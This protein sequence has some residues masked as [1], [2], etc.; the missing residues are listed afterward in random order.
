MRPDEHKKK[1]RAEYKKKHGISN[2]KTA[3]RERHETTKDVNPTE[4]REEEALADTDEGDH[5]QFSR[6]N[7]SSNWDRY[8]DFEGSSDEE[9]STTNITKRG[10][11]FN[12]LLQKSE[13]PASQFRFQ[14]EKDLDQEIEGDPSTTQVAASA[15]EINFGALA[16]SLNCV[17]LHK[18]LDISADG[19]HSDVV[20]EFELNAG[21]HLKDQC[22]LPWSSDDETPTKHTVKSTTTITTESRPSPGSALQH[23]LSPHSTKTNEQ[24][25]IDR[26]PEKSGNDSKQ[27]IQSMKCDGADLSHVKQAGG[28]S[29]PRSLHNKENLQNS[30]KDVL[31]TVNT[32]SKA[33]HTGEQL[34]QLG[35][36]E[37]DDELEF[38]LSLETPGGKDSAKS[39]NGL[40]SNKV[41]KR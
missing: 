31:K 6:R 9:D 26:T 35:N 10:E 13:N 34:V 20:K 17:P 32:S 5:K 7:V 19:I 3:S 2:K 36:N 16:A 37:D 21:L 4:T 24:D 41:S 1:H 23:S 39:T 29:E 15:L 22:I 30:L 38:L 14:S 28:T 12:V 27:S 33:D 18:R 25:L 40:Q 11:D 8:E